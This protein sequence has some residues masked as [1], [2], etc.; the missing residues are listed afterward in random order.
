MSSYCVRWH[1]LKAAIL[2]S[3]ITIQTGVLGNL[4]EGTVANI[5]DGPA[6]TAEG[7]WPGEA[8]RASEEKESRAH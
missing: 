2:G 8:E 5:A 4:E 3:G 1:R 6:I 7:Y